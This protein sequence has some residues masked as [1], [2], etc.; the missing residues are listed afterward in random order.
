[1]EHVPKWLNDHLISNASINSGVK[2]TIKRSQGINLET[3]FNNFYKICQAS[4]LEF[5]EVKKHK[6][7]LYV[8]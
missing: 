7:I 2:N 1:M 6:P 5:I 4:V 8:Q 3:S